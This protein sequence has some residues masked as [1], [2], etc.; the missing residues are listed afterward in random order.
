MEAE[1]FRL[2]ERL[3]HAALE[4]PAALRA[5]FLRERCGEDAE[6]RESVDNLLAGDER[7]AAELEEFAPF[8]PRAD[9]FLGRRL[10][11]WR[12]VE[13]IAEGGMGVVYRAERDDGL[14]ERE[15]A[16]KLLRVDVATEDALRRF[17]QERRLLARLEHPHIAGLLDGGRTELGTPYLVMELVDGLSIDRWCDE[18]ALSVDARLRLFVDACRAVHYAHQN[19]VV[20]RDLKPSNVMVDRRGDVKLL[21]FGI[22]R[23]QDDSD[24]DATRTVAAR[25]TPQYASP[26]Q[27]Q[28]L[29][30]TT[31][32][33][34][35][36]L[37]VLLYELLTG[38]RPWDDQSAS[39][40]WRRAP[41]RG[42][43]RRPSTAVSGV[44]GPAVQLAARRGTSPAHLRRHLRGDLDRIVLMALRE[45]PER[46]Y[47][48]AE[49]FAEDVER[50]L[51]QLPVRAQRDTL[52]Y[53]AQR[54]ARR[55][56]AALAAAGAV[57]LALLLGLVVSLREAERARVAR[58]RAERTAEHARIEADSFRLIAQWMGDSL[59]RTAESEPQRDWLAQ[60]LGRYAEQVRR[61]HDDHP[62]LR[63]NLLDAIGNAFL[64]L[65]LFERAEELLTEARDVRLATFGGRTME[66]ALS[67]GS[68][69]L[70]EHRRGRPEA[71]ALHFASALE[72]HRELGGDVHTDVAL[73]A[74]DLAVALR[75]LGRLD[76]ARALHEE[77][78]E[79]R[80]AAAEEP[81][82]LVAESLNNLAVVLLDQFDAEHAR[83]L[84]EEALEI[85]R[86]ILGREHELSLQT[87]GVFAG[88]EWRL[89]HFD[90][91]AQ[92]LRDA[93]EG[94]RRL[95]AAGSEGLAVNLG[96]LAALELQ[97]GELEQA[98]AHALESLG[99]MLGL[100]GPE[101][102]RT[103]TARSRVAALHLESGDLGDARAAWAEVL[104]V[105]RAAFPADHP[106]L[107]H[108]LTQLANVLL[109]DD[110]A[111][112]AEPLL[113]E[114]SRILAR[115]GDPAGR[116]AAS[117]ELSLGLCA[118]QQG[119]T[120]EARRHL[121]RARALF[122][123]LD[124]DGAEG[125]VRARDLLA[126]LPDAD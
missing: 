20:H 118:R 103:A 21:D 62:H 120:H 98:R 80:R 90:A 46:R 124:G 43:P 88:V 8:P 109:Q 121:E 85:R 66:H 13:R 86:R 6:L 82:L 40:S 70:L 63:A 41:G 18:R 4:L 25:L 23:L 74:N 110:V 123:A 93:V 36:S 30:L 77:A 89:G 35:Y 91:S 58:A 17:D 108:T 19:L 28:G 61:Q 76:E 34:V 60:A 3:F 96:N 107:V 29:P 94:Y 22:A 56:R 71:A 32:T 54:F 87:L 5:P 26:E 10:G 51:Q 12:I 102:P 111:A 101:H 27:L 52:G 7:A 39:P 48:S 55:N 59:L 114:A 117:L 57:L 14:F 81:T 99:L 97:V 24:L 50:F 2:V 38:R 44:E 73:A 53:R 126:S 119:R 69:G 125:V 45:E 33:D 115:S 42:E 113:E 1:R 16:I 84:V 65:D 106:R 92:A 78:L 49:Q 105:Q 67:L 31:A 75:A 37:G 116:E 72:L 100:L 104:R 47:A 68:L 9:A 79:L 15:V 11:P 64:Q 112:E 122:A 95:G 83:G